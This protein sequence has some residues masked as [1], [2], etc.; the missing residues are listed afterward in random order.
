MSADPDTFPPFARPYSRPTVWLVMLLAGVILALWLIGTPRGALDK[1]DAVGYAICHRIPSR[2]FHIHSR[3]LPLCA[4]CTGI[5]LGVMTGLLVYVASGRSRA[6][7]LP[8]IKVLVLLMLPGVAIGLDGLNSY[9]SLFEFYQPVYTP[10]N[11]LRLITG[12]YAGLTMITLVLPVFNATVWESPL[13]DKVLRSLKELAALYVIAALVIVLV[14][15]KQPAIL[16]IGGLLSVAGVVLMFTVVGSVL[17]MTSTRHENT[18]TRWR[19]L[20]LPLL[21]GLA[22][23]FVVIGAI[24]AARYLFTGTWGG[25][26]MLGG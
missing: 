10:N 9:F 1:A 21:A 26:T 23:A 7:R 11:T 20:A 2:S 15:L 13:P 8:G 16:L 5:Y 3:A 24:D 14:L 19:D 25:F 18:A 22:F 6:S 4:R 12:V 17:F